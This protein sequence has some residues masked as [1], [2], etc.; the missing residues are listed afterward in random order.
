MSPALAGAVATSI[1]IQPIQQRAHTGPSQGNGAIS[2]SVVNV[3]GVAIGV[4]RVS[5][6]K[7][8]IIHVAV[9]LVL[10][11]RPEDPRIAA[12]QTLFRV[13]QIEQGQAQGDTGS[14]KACAALR[15][16]APASLWRSRSAAATGRSCWRPTRRRGALPASAGA[17]PN[18]AD[19]ESRKSTCALPA[20]SWADE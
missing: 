19:R 11:L 4:H 12:Q 16:R 9:A 6:R 20:V 8:D 10:G 13:L 2:G 15:G 1:G 18:G 3:D 14:R 17:G 5:A 7:H